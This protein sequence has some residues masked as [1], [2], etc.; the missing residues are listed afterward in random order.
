MV[1]G[2]GGTQEYPPEWMHVAARKMW[3]Y[4]VFNVFVTRRAEQQVGLLG[5]LQKPLWVK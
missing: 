4:C 2:P 3:E 5:I 1:D